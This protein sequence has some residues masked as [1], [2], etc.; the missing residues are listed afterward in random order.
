MSAFASRWAATAA[1]M[2]KSHVGQSKA[3]LGLNF[4]FPICQDV[5]R[6]DARYQISRWLH[7]S[8]LAAIDVA[9]TTKRDSH[10]WLS[11]LA[12][13]RLINSLPEEGEGPLNL[14]RS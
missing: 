11:Q 13:P 1:R 6:H 10:H 9:P 12:V 2:H 4:S 14:S 3:P 5:P 7:T 8:S